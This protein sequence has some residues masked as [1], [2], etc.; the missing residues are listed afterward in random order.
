MIWV[1]ILVGIGVVLLA[2]LVLWAIWLAHK[3]GDVFHQLV[4]LGG[5]L[6]KLAEQVGRLDLGPLEQ[7]AP[8][9]GD[10]PGTDAAQLPS[11]GAGAAVAARRARPRRE[12]PRAHGQPAR[13]ARVSR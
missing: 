13:D 3:A 8:R 9:A 11:H 7:P 4:D 2:S 1:W 5:K 12:T 6:G 10:L